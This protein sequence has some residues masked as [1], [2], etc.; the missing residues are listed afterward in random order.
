MS[1]VFYVFFLRRWTRGIELDTAVEDGNR[2]AFR[3][4]DALG[5]AS[6]G[7]LDPERLKIDSEAV[8]FGNRSLRMDEPGV[9]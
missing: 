3:V 2:R 1:P 7:A 8:I 4:F 6:F 5:T 9:P